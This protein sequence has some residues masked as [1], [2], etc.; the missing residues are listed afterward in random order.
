VPLHYLKV[1]QQYYI[2]CEIFLKMANL[3]DQTF[4]LVTGHMLTG[5]C[6]N[7]VHLVTGHTL[8]W[9]AQNETMYSMNDFK[10]VTQSVFKLCKV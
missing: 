9:I 2:E 6:Q 3:N 10:K 8:G 5:Q 7:F 4:W 1:G